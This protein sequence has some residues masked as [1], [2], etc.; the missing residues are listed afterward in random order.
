[1]DIN[2]NTVLN[3]IQRCKC[4]SRY[5]SVYTT[6]VLTPCINNG[7]NV[8]FQSD[9]STPGTKYVIKYNFSLAGRTITVP[10]NCIL[11]F[12]GGVL[13]NGTIIGQNTYI[14]DVGGLGTDVI[15][16]CNITRD[17][18]WRGP[19]CEKLAEKI[20]ELEALI[21]KYHP[22]DEPEPEDTIAY[23]LIRGEL[24][25]ELLS[26]IDTNASKPK[27]VQKIILP[28][29]ISGP[30][31]MLLVYPLEWEK[32]VDDLLTSPIILDSHA[33][34]QMMEYNE[35]LPTVTINSKVYRVMNV[36]LG[37]DNYTIEFK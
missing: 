37:V 8:L 29:G 6:V 21:K 14:I 22:E 30:T 24:T 19:C 12:D 35:E 26:K 2:F 31:S 33:M 4:S 25:E 5:N 9:M 15:F 36:E 7:S 16:S 18:T 10:E 13:T 28:E 32:I 23:L 11:E 27:G 20:A 17:G 3:K 1:M 34:P